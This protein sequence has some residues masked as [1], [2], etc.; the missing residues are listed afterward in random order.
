[1]IARTTIAFAAGFASLLSPCVLPLVPGYLSTV[2]AL[3]A[4]QLGRPGTARR[5][6]VGGIPFVLGFTAVF[7][8]LGAAASALA[9]LVSKDSQEAIAGFLLVVVGLAFMGLLPLPKRVVGV[10]LIGEARRVGS[11]ALL[12]AAFAVCA[13]PC[14]GAVL[15]GV[16][17]LASQSGTVLRGSFLLA[18]YSA[19]LAV[20]F[21]LAGVAFA[22][23]MGAF[24]W[25]RN[26]FVAMQTASGAV[27]V[28]LGLLFFFD[29]ERALRIIAE[30]LL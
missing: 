23:A 17:V 16:L 14:I 26:H 13:A 18:A 6:L 9:A 3:E 2:A 7:V 19:G 11:N 22:R 12:G 25:L 15:G 21:L 1:M 10:G 4:G 30:R 28:A 27:L 5:V 29:R 8:V 20:A 24:R